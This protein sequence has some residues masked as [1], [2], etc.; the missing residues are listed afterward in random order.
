MPSKKSLVLKKTKGKT[1]RKKNKTFRKNSLERTVG[2]APKTAKQMLKYYDLL[3]TQLKGYTQKYS[4]EQLEQNAQI[5]FTRTKWEMLNSSRGTKLENFM[6]NIKDAILKQ[7][8]NKLKQIVSMYYAN[9]VLNT[10]F[11]YRDGDKVIGLT[12]LLLASRENFTEGVK[13]L[14]AQPGINVNVSSGLPVDLQ[15][16]ISQGIGDYLDTD[17]TVGWLYRESVLHFAVKTGN[18]DLVNILTLIQNLNFNIIDTS[19]QTPLDLAVWEQQN[20]FDEITRLTERV[21]QFNRDVDITKFNAGKLVTYDPRPD[22]EGATQKKEALTKII[23]ILQ[24]RGALTRVDSY[25]RDKLE[26]AKNKK[27]TAYVDNKE[28]TTDKT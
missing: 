22:L 10:T 21:E 20:N 5:K 7:D 2:G 15:N 4:R 14:I 18:E 27:A 9:D 6:S 3:P 11:D 26:E 12:P 24:N 17:R 19:K 28:V 13:I 23:P 1:L 8:A 25:S 16:F